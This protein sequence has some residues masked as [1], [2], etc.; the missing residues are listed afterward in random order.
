MINDKILKTGFAALLLSAGL[1]ATGCGSVT[2]YRPKPE[3]ISDLTPVEARKLLLKVAGRLTGCHTQVTSGMVTYE[4]FQ[5]NC[6]GGPF[7]YADTPSLVAMTYRG[8]PV[9]GRGEDKTCIN[10]KESSISRSTGRGDWR[11]SK[12][13]M[14]YSTGVNLP[15]SRDFVRAWTVL[16][17]DGA[18]FQRARETAFGL[19]AKTYRESPEKPELPEGAV[20]FKAQAE[21]AVREKR[22]GDAADLYDEALAVAPWW[23]AGHYNRGLIL[24]ELKDYE[25]AV[26]ELKRYLAVD[27]DAA[28]ARAVQ[29]KVYEWE[30]LV[31]KAVN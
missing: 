4:R 7:R 24:G 26:G 23:P 27:P 2:V 18:A 17:R 30:A 8:D 14:F 22:F 3:E 31:P 19:A 28:N 6:S 25:G 15:A 21:G 16:A 20:R 10:S 12:D 9:E 11:G 1:A 13:C 29:L 5:S